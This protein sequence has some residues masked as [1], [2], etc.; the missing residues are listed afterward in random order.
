VGGNPELVEEHVTGRLI[1]SRDPR[2]LAEAMAV[3]LDDP[4]VRAVHGKAARERAM[5]RFSLERMCEGYVDLYRRLLG[6]R[7][8]PGS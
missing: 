3:Y 4:H 5:E 2:A 1:R 7:L 6:G 8:A